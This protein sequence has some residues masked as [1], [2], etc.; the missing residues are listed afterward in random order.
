MKKLA[1]VIILLVSALG[2]SQSDSRFGLKGGV[3]LATFK[4]DVG[5]VENAIAYHA[6]LVFEAPI[7]NRL[8][9][10][11]EFV[12]TVKGAKLSSE[13]TLL[14]VKFSG[15]TKNQLSYINVP[16]ILKLYLSDNVSIQAGPHLGYLLSAERIVESSVEKDDS[17]TKTSG[18]VDIKDKYESLD[19]GVSVGLGFKLN[20]N[21]ILGGRY[22]MGMANILKDSK[23]TEVMNNV[24][25]LYLGFLF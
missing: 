6:G 5:E 8:S 13:S 18:S 23:N 2:Y 22:E 17:S 16:L 20:N 24:M 11:P 3:N 4:G 1:V 14:G 15:E 12:Y 7:G 25:Q 10:Q 9:F 21:I 19:Y